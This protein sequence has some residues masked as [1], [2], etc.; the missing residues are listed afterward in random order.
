M[1]TI[2]VKITRQMHVYKT[3][4]VNNVDERLNCIEM[5]VNDFEF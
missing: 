4:N 1:L 3:K 5:K 2:K